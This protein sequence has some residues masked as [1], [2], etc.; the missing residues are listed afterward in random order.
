MFEELLKTLVIT[1]LAGTAFAG[2][3]TLL[4]PITRRVFGAA[5][6]YYIW[7][8]VLAVM[9]LPVRFSVPISVD[10]GGVTNAVAGV[11]EVYTA[12]TD[13]TAAAPVREAG[14]TAAQSAVRGGS[15]G[16][17]ELAQHGAEILFA[18]W[19]LGAALSLLVSVIGYL[20]LVCAVRKM[21]VVDLP[22]IGRYTK[23]K[24]AVRAGGVSSPFIMGIFHPLLVLP[25][26]EF[27]AEELDNILRHEMTHLRR[28]DILYKH[29]AVLVRCVHW[30][31]PV[32]YYAVRQ[33]SAECEISCDMAA[34]KGMDDDERRGYMRTILALLSAGGAKNNALTTGMACGKKVMRR[35]FIMIKSNRATS[36]IVSVL[37]AVIAAVIF[38]A[39][40][41]ASGVLADLTAESETI[42]YTAH[43]LGISVE[44]PASWEGKYV[45]E[46][47]YYDTDL[48]ILNVAQKATYEKYDGA[49][50]LFRIEKCRAASAEEILN[51]LGGSRL[52]YS[53]D[54]YA[55][56]FEI[57]TDVQYPI[58]VDRD[59]ED[60]AI[61]E[62]Y[63][64][65][66]KEV[67]SIA[68]SF[69]FSDALSGNAAQPA[70][71]YI[72][73]NNVSTAIVWQ[74]FFYFAHSDFEN[75]KKYCTQDFIDGYF[76]DGFVFGM[77][78]ASLINMQID[79][80]QYTG[81]GECSVHVTVA[82][83]PAEGS[84]YSPDDTETE[85]D[86][87]LLRQA[88]GVYLI[89]EFGR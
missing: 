88:N 41:F 65:M 21:P 33:I 72:I 76:G 9:I 14:V 86:I 46:T 74:F 82:M 61:S 8:A 73:E 75:M 20:R 54:Q 13:V 36:K 87:Q 79:P 81:S 10:R 70:E 16:T 31:N 7:L 71:E 27:S 78:S 5:W 37:S 80:T 47:S 15:A 2:V 22:E 25:E 38:A 40:V 6:H 55:Y 58:W 50:V 69:K 85:F 62:E 35:R 67:G 30:F 63:E 42:L 53:N 23:R 57:P 66:F 52:L 83:K 39:T 59:K 56:I 17:F 1:T 19:I 60:I 77:E 51:M 4:K 26:R 12:P 18:V 64:E 49:G 84:V 32:V 44:I 43:D 89:N 24:V 28:G 45:M 29:F 48:A 34:V 11:Q 68:E 3:V